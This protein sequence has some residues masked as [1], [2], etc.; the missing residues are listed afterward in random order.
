MTRIPVRGMITL[1]MALT[2]AALAGRLCAQPDEYTEVVDRLSEAKARGSALVTTIGHSAEGRPIFAAIV[3]LRHPKSGTLE[4]QLKNDSRP[5]LLVLCGQHGDEPLPV[6]VAL[7]LIKSMKND[8]RDS[9]QNVLVAFIPT[10]NPDGFV[11]RKRDNARGF[12]LNRDWANSRQPE[13]EAVTEFINK[14]RPHVLIDQHEWVEGDTY[15]PNCLEMA[16][17]GHRSQERLARMLAK[18]IVTSLSGKSISIQLTHYSKQADKRMAHRWFTDC[19]IASILVETSPDKPEDW[20]NQVYKGVVV[21]AMHALSAPPN[22]MINNDIGVLQ[23]KRPYATAWASTEV[24][25]LVDSDTNWGV[26]PVSISLATIAIAFAF[27]R[28]K[29][30]KR[31][32]QSLSDGRRICFSE[33]VQC[34]APIHIRLEMIHN[35]RTRPSDRRCIQP[36]HRAI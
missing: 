15:R 29:T 31:P 25:S 21:S 23:E 18:S 30:Q 11:A 3:G 24:V 26:Y 16:S 6:Y 14:F 32:E 19:G 34:D 36:S 13:T 33:A 10:V 9:L 8:Q 35:L 7:D 4:D 2:I 28:T 12:D 17:F 5:R 20:R 22:R 1:L 27:V